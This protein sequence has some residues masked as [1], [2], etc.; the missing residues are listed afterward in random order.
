MKSRTSWFPGAVVSLSLL[1][2]STCLHATSFVAPSN[3]GELG[4]ASEMV[5]LARAGDDSV[6]GNWPMLQTV[7]EFEVLETVKGKAGLE[8]MI[9]VSVPGG[10]R[11]GLGWEPSGT[12][13]F[14][15]GET[16]LLFLN[17]GS[18]GFWA[19]LL[20][21]LGVF[22]QSESG[23]GKTLSTVPEAAG[24]VLNSL[25]GFSGG[26]YQKDALIAHLRETV[27]GGVK[28]SDEKAGAVEALHLSATPAGCSLLECSG[29]NVRFKE[30]DLG[31]GISI[32]ADRSGDPSIEGGGFSELEGAIKDWNSISGTAI[33]IQYGGAVPVSMTCTANN[34]DVP[35]LGT[36]AVVFN[37]PCSDI[38]DFVN[39]WGT[40]AFGG[41]YFSTETHTFD[42]R[43][44]RTILGWFVVVNNGAGF[45]GSAT[46]RSM[47]A[48]ELGHGLGF[49]HSAD[50]TSLM[51]PAAGNRM[52]DADKDCYR[53]YY[54]GNKVVDDGKETLMV[55]VVMNLGSSSVNYFTEVVI[56]NRSEESPRA[57][58][59]FRP[60]DAAGDL[61]GILE[62]GPGSQIIIPDIIAWLTSQGSRT[63]NPE[64][65]GEIGTLRIEIEGASQR[66]LIHVSA[67]TK[68]GTSDPQPEGAAGL[69]YPGV[70]P[71]VWKKTAYTVYGLR[72]NEADRSNLAFFNTGETPVRLRVK[73]HAGDGSGRVKELS[74]EIEIPAYGWKQWN[75]VL[76]MA[77]MENGWVTVERVGTSG[78]F[79]VYGVVNDNKTNDGS[80]LLPA[81]EPGTGK[82]LTVPALVETETVRSELVLTNRSKE[83]AF[84]TLGYT[85]SGTGGIGTETEA[86]FELAG[87]TQLILSDALGFLRD[88]GLAG[89]ACGGFHFGTL[90]ITVDGIALSEFYAG[91][92]TASLSPAGG[93]FGL[94]TPAVYSGNEAVSEAFLYG[95]IADEENRSNVALIN[96]AAKGGG[97]VT[98]E[99]RTF[100]GDDEGRE[101][102]ERR[103]V[104]LL[105]GQIKQFNNLLKENGIESG[106]AQVVKISGNSRFICY[107]VINDGG[108][109]GER[110][111]DGA[112]VAMT[113]P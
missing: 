42:K 70:S 49:G 21:A 101:K 53:Y 41:P 104:R 88:L 48:H 9:Q 18:G 23:K 51:Y 92:R 72:S 40:L 26:Q 11:D 12:P 5:I 35:P 74:P 7:T 90:R 6:L 78:S 96:A 93:Q 30:F 66:G 60:A 85:E 36:N 10:H 106:W 15:R 24:S 31:M 65:G 102:G 112:Y 103:T 100:D 8:S 80:F 32:V 82:A 86:V 22:E 55:P 34:M 89:N 84:L 76:E 39:G 62:L 75:R 45:V 91:A 52:S 1:F 44:V 67:R 13:R 111:G 14:R 108:N 38:P 79:G 47:M 46:Y 83:T 59:L 58:L 16:Y 33:E 94:F 69:S 17:S 97:S 68:A 107:G 56:T 81:D 61:E 63:R 3:L 73:A 28:W 71:A 54:P 110:T 99:V 29:Q 19:P 37:D 20:G 87:E 50:K 109:P 27:A 43:P 64:E 4:S 113:K 77:D 98:L 95:L 105:P 2:V 25:D 57:K